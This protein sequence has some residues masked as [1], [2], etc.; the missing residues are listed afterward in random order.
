MSNIADY[1]TYYEELSKVRKE[2][3]AQLGQEIADKKIIPPLSLIY[4]RRFKDRLYNQVAKILS[5]FKTDLRILDIG[6][7]YG[8]DL[9]YIRGYFK[10]GTIYGIDISIN[11]LFMAV[12]SLK[13]DDSYR[14]IQS[15]AEHISFKNASFDAVIFSEII[16]HLPE[17]ELALREISRVLKNEGYLFITTP[18]KYS[19]FHAF[20]TLI[21]KKNRIWLS[22]KLKGQWDIDPSKFVPHK[23]MKEH[24]SLFSLFS[25]ERLLKKYGFLIK[26]I[27]GGMLEI[28]FPYL[29]DRHPILIR[30]WELID[31]ILDFLPFSLYLKAN[32]IIVAKK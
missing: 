13:G 12:E 7:G 17:P 19:Y 27:K 31:K 20:G 14:L 23:D 10:Q 8:E 11:Q 2:F 25:L 18:N 30:L 3:R 1:R 28:P 21:P 9:P 22:R 16:E 26:N 5:Q 24:I 15:Y 29:F 4:Y 32:F 6:C